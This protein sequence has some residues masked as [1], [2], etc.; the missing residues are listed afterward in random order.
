MFLSFE[1]LAQNTLEMNEI[2][3]G[4]GGLDYIKYS[5]KTLI[6]RTRFAVYV[7]KSFQGFVVTFFKLM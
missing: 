7:T 2:A 1:I 3:K 4:K 5:S 6:F